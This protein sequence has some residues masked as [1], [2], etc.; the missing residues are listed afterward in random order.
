M[1]P[2]ITIKDLSRIYHV[3]KGKQKETQELVA[4]RQVNLMAEQGEIVGLLGP[5]G[6]GKTT[7][8]KILATIL[9]PTTGRVEIL[10]YDVVRQQKEIRRHIGLSFGGDQGF[11]TRL[12][13]RDNLT[14]WAAL[15][16]MPRRTITQQV[17]NILELMGLRAIADQPV[18]TLSRGM[19]Q[20]LHLARGLLPNPKVLLL[21]EPTIGLD[22]VAAHALRKLVL[23]LKSEG[24]TIFLTTHSMSE[25]E[26]LC[27]RIAILS[28]GELRF[29]GTPSAFKHGSTN[30]H[31]LFLRVTKGAESKVAGL[32]STP[33]VQHMNFEECSEHWNISI[34]YE[35][36]YPLLSQ[37][38]HSLDGGDILELRSREQTLEDAYIQLV[39]D[40][41]LEV[42][43]Q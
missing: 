31:M 22:P 10:G 29:T 13:A 33:A 15:Y 21:D 36:A 25:A 20:R 5:N 7:L 34:L 24:L 4:L 2:A 38:L 32:S 12:S 28:H 41:G 18:E 35:K 3:R 30:Q 27:D 1:D 40:Q 6:A 17:S 39:G 37:I 42:N 14:F 11:Y 9:L 23:Q 8:V 16:Q 26:E 43:K 19:R